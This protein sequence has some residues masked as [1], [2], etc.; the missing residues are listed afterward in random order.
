LR[1]FSAPSLKLALPK[2]IGAIAR[3]AQTR[4]GTRDGKGLVRVRCEFWNLSEWEQ[5]G[6]GFWNPRGKGAT[7]T[8]TI[9]NARALA[10]E[11]LIELGALM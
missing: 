6:I 2:C 7:I 4:M 10:R 8:D 5:S 11:R 3:R 9:D 1:Y